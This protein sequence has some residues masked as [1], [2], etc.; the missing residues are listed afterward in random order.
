M[1][2][3]IKN[4]TIKGFERTYYKLNMNIEENKVVAL[5]SNDKKAINDFFLK[6]SGV[7]KIQGEVLFRGNHVFDNEEYFDNRLL[8]DYSKC[9]LT[10]L[11]KEHLTNYFKD[12][13]DMEIDLNIFEKINKELRLRNEYLIKDRYIFTKRG[14]NLV[15]Y[16][17]TISINKGINFIKNTVANCS[18]EER[19]IIFSG[20]SNK[21]ASS[22]N[23]LDL[24]D[25]LIASQSID[26]YLIFSNG[27]EIITL[28]NDDEIYVVSGEI[29]N[30]LLYNKAKDI[31]VTNYNYN[32]NEIKTM[33]K[34]KMMIKKIKLMD[35]ERYL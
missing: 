34:R 2:L 28:T 25:K 27:G 23:F 8:I 35:V 13:F 9:Y 18:K 17:L 11:D 29:V 1:N 6:I 22:I 7:N 20:L 31:S 10:T 24:Q 16:A 26:I 21:G 14:L 4:V 5:I 33:K 15:N 12:N 30:S 19:E 32:K 3:E